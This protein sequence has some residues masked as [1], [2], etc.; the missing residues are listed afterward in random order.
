MGIRDIFD[1]GKANLSGLVESSEPISVTEVIH[2]AIIEVDEEGTEAAA[3]TGI[4]TANKSGTAFYPEPPKF[5]ADHGFVYHVY[6]RNLK[7]AIFSGH[8]T[9]L[10]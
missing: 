6:D 4:V 9:R 7:I 8:V 3:A 5:D 1:S 10:E 2:K